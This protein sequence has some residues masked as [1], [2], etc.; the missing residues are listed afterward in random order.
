MQIKDVEKL[1][2]LTAKSI[3]YYESK[4][5][6]TVERKEENDYRNYTEENIHRL[7]E[8]KL[9]R[10]LDFSIEEIK[11]IFDGETERIEE[12]LKEAA[13][14]KAKY[15]EELSTEQHTKQELCLALAKDY[16]SDAAIIDEYNETIDFLESEDMNQLKNEL[17]HISCPSLTEVCFETFILLAPVLWLFINIHAERI[18]MLMFNA[19]CAIA[20]A[21]LITL[22][23]KNF[24]YKRRFYKDK[25]KQKD[26][27]K[28]T[29][30]PVMVLSVLGSIAVLLASVM[31]LENWMI[32]EDYLFWCFD[33]R[34]ELLLI[35]CLMLPVL[36][37]ISLCAVKLQKRK[38]KTEELTEEEW[39]DR[40][41][42][43][44]IYVFF[45]KHIISALLIWL[46]CLYI[47]ITSLTV[48]TE[49]SIVRYSPLCPMGK[50]YSYADVEKVEAGYGSKLFSISYYKRQG[51]FSYTIYLDGKKCI[52]YGPDANED[53]ER[54][55]EHSYLEL[56]EFD[57]K[58][59]ELGIPKE[60]SD[61]NSEDALLDQEYL[62]RFLRII[63]NK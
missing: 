14:K 35:V 53:I 56:E 52:F 51:E 25:I 59:M 41:L 57:A 30:F 1:T 20:S 23:W 45:T 63:N 5:M 46:C 40:P 38:Y 31:V 6:I 62:D 4:G 39:L 10:Y 26:R 29:V 50:E 43:L 9:L 58:L 15:Y 3:R 12:K 54:Y 42:I 37:F 34:F 7:K 19:V 13:S 22:T 36:M 27:Y 61:A 11:Q 28:W 21:V 55:M 24:F 48:V 2:G 49:T 44:D 16:K 60:S 33:P 18:N 8:I 47:C 17:V 32:P